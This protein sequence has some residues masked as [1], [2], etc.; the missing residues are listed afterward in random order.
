MSNQKWEKERPLLSDY[1]KKSNGGLFLSTVS[2]RSGRK[3]H[4]WLVFA[5]F[6]LCLGGMGE[7]SLSSSVFGSPVPLMSATEKFPSRLIGPPRVFTFFLKSSHTHN[8][9]R[10][11]PVPG[12]AQVP[13]TARSPTTLPLMAQETSEKE[14]DVPVIREP[15]EKEKISSGE[16]EAVEKDQVS[17]VVPEAKEQE[18]ISPGEGAAQKKEEAPPGIQEPQEKK[19]TSSEETENL[20]KE[21]ISPGEAEPV[22]KEQIPPVAPEGQEKEKA[23]QGESRSL[24]KEQVH[25]VVPNIQE[26]EKEKSPP[27]LVPGVF[28]K[29]KKAPPILVPE[30]PEKDN[31]QAIKS[32]KTKIQETRDLIRTIDEGRLTRE[33]H[34]TFN[35]IHSFLEKS[36]EAFSQDDMSMAVNLAEKAHTLAKEIVRNSSKE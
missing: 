32:Y 26:K 17:P 34:D 29:E 25:P 8:T 31:G 5:L 1:L 30:V 6:C 21:K 10:N 7:I 2:V 22:E 15:Q 27:V 3:G 36:K 4:R 16:A 33:Q 24:E 14:K 18:N 28:E 20:E 11:S 19:K 9:D 12:D 35:S 23:S 13:N